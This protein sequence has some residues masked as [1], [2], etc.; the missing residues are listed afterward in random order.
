MI[1]GA[2]LMCRALEVQP[3]PAAA[4][5][6]SA[7]TSAEHAAPSERIARFSV[8][9]D[10]SP[11]EPH[12]VAEALKIEFD[13]GHSDIVHAELGP[14]TLGKDDA[15]PQSG[16]E[17]IQIAGDHRTIG[18]LATYMICAQSYPCAAE[19]VVFRSGHVTRRITPDTGIVWNWIFWQNGR[20]VA[21]HSGFPHGDE[22]GAYAL[23][24][25]ETGQRVAS[26]ARGPDR[27][28]W[29]EALAKTDP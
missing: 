11:D 18:W 25:A 21:V 8:V 19:L 22:D 17:N 9:S 28:A 14:S 27:P 1:L 3:A 26:Y 5:I 2:L 7:P 12:D 20:Q 29:A 13:D 6:D 4:P 15:V 24:D 10:K 23:Y 16:F